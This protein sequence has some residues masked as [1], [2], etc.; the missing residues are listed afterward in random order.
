M[1]YDGHGRAVQLT[2]DLERD[3]DGQA[4]YIID[5]LRDYEAGGIRLHVRESAPPDHVRPPATTTT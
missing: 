1:T 4:R 2:A 5:L 3:E